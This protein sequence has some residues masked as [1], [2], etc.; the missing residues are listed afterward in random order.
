[1]GT[2]VYLAQLD[3]II[4]QHQESVN[5]V[6][7]DSLIMKLKEDAHARNKLHICIKT[8][9]VLIA[10]HLISGTVKPN[11]VMLVH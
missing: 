9:L 4:I 1:M 11:L 6:H 3:L 5:Y 8:V 10:S 2:N 7:Q